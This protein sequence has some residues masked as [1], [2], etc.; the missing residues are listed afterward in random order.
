MVK[1]LEGIKGINWEV[2]G[3]SIV[4]EYIDQKGNVV[5]LVVIEPPSKVPNVI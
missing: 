5:S 3:E 4:G 1:G 2:K